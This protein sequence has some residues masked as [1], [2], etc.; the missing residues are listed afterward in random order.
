MV[1]RKKS[2]S[3]KK[4]KKAS[5][6]GGGS[7]DSKGDQFDR[8]GAHF[9]PGRRRAEKNHGR[10]GGHAQGKKKDMGKTF[11]ERV[12]GKRVNPPQMVAESFDGNA[13]KTQASGGRK[14]ILRAPSPKKMKDYDWQR[15]T[16]G[17]RSRFPAGS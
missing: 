17:I 10:K 16:R 8:N 3:Q 7:G 2:F 11:G 4:E 14:R 12:Q 6:K 5:I 1:H 13:T 9:Q 15:P